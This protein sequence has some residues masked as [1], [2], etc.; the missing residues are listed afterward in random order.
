MTLEQMAD[1]VCEDCGVLM[2][3]VHF[4]RKLCYDCAKKRRR[5]YQVQYRKAKREKRESNNNP[6]QEHIAN[7]N[8]K[9]CKG[10]VYWGAAYEGNE[11]CNYIFV[12]GHSRPCPPG[13]GCTEK[14]VGKRKRAVDCGEEWW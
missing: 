13:K 7:P 12:E 6:P 4:E 11:C 8:E 2:S 5:D 9:H 3:N 14:I 10:C 1:K